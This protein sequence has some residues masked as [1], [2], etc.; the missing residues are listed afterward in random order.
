MPGYQNIP[1]YQDMREYQEHTW[2]SG[3]HLDIRY[4]PGYQEHI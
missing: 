4:T 3:T 1:G 2:I